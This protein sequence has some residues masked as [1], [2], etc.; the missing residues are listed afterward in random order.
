M[1]IGS[2]GRRKQLVAER[3]GQSIA[4]LLMLVSLGATD[5]KSMTLNSDTFSNLNGT[6]QPSVCAT[7]Q[8]IMQVLLD[9]AVAQ[10]F[11]GERSCSCQITRTIA[12]SKQ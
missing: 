9:T 11:H 10:A 1:S 7:R 12:L 5:T 2:T 6:A 3:Y 8:V 4:S